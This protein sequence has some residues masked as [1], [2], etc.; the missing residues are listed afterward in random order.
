MT[1]V[2]VIAHAEKTLGGGL[3][4]L[5]RILAEEGVTDPFWRE[6]SKSKEAPRFA[7]EALDEG[8]DPILLWGGDGTVQRC[9]DTLA[10]SGTTIAIV[11][12]GTANLLASN[13][14]IPTDIRTAVRIALNGARRVLDVG[15]MNGERFVV[16]AGVGLDAMMIRDAD[17]GV[18]DRLGRAA[19]V[20]AGAKN[21][22]T[23]PMR[24]R[25]R[26]DD[27]KWFKGKASCVLFGNVGTVLGGITVFKD[28]RP[29]DGELE[30][31]VLTAEG[32]SQW[33]RIAGRTAIGQPERSP[34]VRTT[35]GHTFEIKLDGKVPYE[36]DGGDRKP[37]KR[38]SVTI[39]PAAIRIAVPVEEVA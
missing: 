4:E 12:A 7:R 30:V 11:P 36:L 2:A 17:G 23:G 37:R 6:V 38:F 32:L 25:L 14:G 19:Y 33:I 34:F 8:A 1:A 31:G 29:D 15:V 39:E 27:A 20:I 35:H 5:R 9:V 21:L 13:L 18:K 26:V 28:A 16:M 3:P 24:V 22:R 10:G